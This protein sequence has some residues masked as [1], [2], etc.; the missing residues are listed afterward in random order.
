[1]QVTKEDGK[2]KYK[3][4]KKALSLEDSQARLKNDVSMLKSGALSLR[5]MFFNNKMI[6]GIGIM[7]MILRDAQDGDAVKRFE[8]D[9]PESVRDVLIAVCGG[10][11]M[12]YRFE[13]VRFSNRVSKGDDGAGLVGYLLDA[14]G[15]EVVRT[16]MTETDPSACA[17]T[18]CQ[19]IIRL[20][21][22]AMV[23]MVSQP[24]PLDA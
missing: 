21:N 2:K 13:M 7:N 17:K 11:K 6:L 18:R 20:F 23:R 3:Y 10:R 12:S 5:Q 14:K 22:E 8:M 19:A 4:K 15:A 16:M 1:M 24:P 9:D